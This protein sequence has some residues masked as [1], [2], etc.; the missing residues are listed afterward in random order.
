M[1]NT[2]A[3]G[4]KGERAIVTPYNVRVYQ[5]QNDITKQMYITHIGYY[6]EAKYHYRV[7]EEGAKENIFIYCEK[8]IGWIEYKEERFV[9]KE[10]CFFI[11]PPPGGEACVRCR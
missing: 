3:D 5:A 8:G 6:P 1:E 7:R 10:N 4:F 11:L 2:L 9:L